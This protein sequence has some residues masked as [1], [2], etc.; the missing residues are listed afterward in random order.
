MDYA[1]HPCDWEDIKYIADKYDIILINDNCHAMG[2]EIN[3][4]KRYAIK[5]ADFVTQSF[6]PVKHIT[7]GEGGAVMT[8]DKHHHDIIKTLSSHGM[9]KSANKIKNSHGPWY[10]EMHQLGYNYRITDIQC[11]LGI[12][13]LKKINYFIEKRKNIA[14]IYDNNL[15]IF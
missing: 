6:H 10:Y 15:K 13:Q 5:Y 12:S 1:G 3:Q 14:S 2:A 7:T 11:A 4:D 9:I 8:N